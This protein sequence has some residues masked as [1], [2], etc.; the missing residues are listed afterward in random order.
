MEQSQTMSVYHDVMTLNRP[1]IRRSQAP[2]SSSD[3]DTYDE[4]LILVPRRW[5]ETWIDW[6]KRSGGQYPSIE[7]RNIGSSRLLCN[8]GPQ[9]RHQRDELTSNAP[10][11]SSTDLLNSTPLSPFLAEDADYKPI[12][13]RAYER[14]L[15]SG[16]S[17]DVG[18][19][20]RRRLVNKMS[21]EHSLEQY[22]HQVKLFGTWD[23][24][25]VSPITTPPPQH[26]H[27][28]NICG[29]F[30]PGVFSYFGPE[31][32]KEVAEKVLDAVE[33]PLKWHQLYDYDLEM[34]VGEDAVLGPRFRR[35][36]S[37]GLIVEEMTE[38][39][40]EASVREQADIG[41]LCGY[42]FPFSIQE[43]IIR[44]LVALDP[45]PIPATESFGE[46]FELLEVTPPSIATLNHWLE[47][48]SERDQNDLIPFVDVND[49][50]SVASSP[51]G[52]PLE[53]TPINAPGTDWINT[54]GSSIISP[55]GQ[56]NGSG[57]FSDEDGDDGEI[58]GT[59]AN[60]IPPKKR[61]GD[62]I[63][64]QLSRSKSRSSPSSMLS[65]SCTVSSVLVPSS[66]REVEEKKEADEN[67]SRGRRGLQ[68][69]GNTCFMNSSLQCLS[70]SEDLRRYFD[71]NEARRIEKLNRN[72]E[73]YDDENDDAKEYNFSLD[74]NMEN[75]LGTRGEFA[76]VFA[77]LLKSLWKPMPPTQNHKS[78]Y[79][80]PYSYNSYNYNNAATPHEFKNVLGRHASQFMGMEQHDSQVSGKICFCLL[81]FISSF[82]N[83][84]ICLLL[85]ARCLQEVANYIIDMLHE[86]TNRVVSKPVTEKIEQGEGESDEESSAKAW[87][88]KL[89]RDDSAVHDIFMGQLKSVVE[90]CNCDKVSTTFDPFMYLTVE[91]PPG[92]KKIK[93][94]YVDLDG[95]FLPFA[96][97]VEDTISYGKLKTLVAVRLGFEGV[98]REDLQCV[99]VFSS[100]VWAIFK[101]EQEVEVS[102]SERIFIYQLDGIVVDLPS[103]PS[104]LP[105][106]PQ[107]PQNN[108][109]ADYESH[110]STFKRK[111]TTG[112]AR[113]D[114]VFKPDAPFAALSR[115]LQDAAKIVSLLKHCPDVVA[116][117]RSASMD[118]DSDCDEEDVEFDATDCLD[119]PK[120]RANIA[121]TWIAIPPSDQL[122]LTFANVDTYDNYV[123]FKGLV[124]KMTAYLDNAMKSK[125]PSCSLGSLGERFKQDNDNENENDDYIVVELN[126][127]ED[128]YN[129]KEIANAF[130]NPLLLRVRKSLSVF[131]LRAVIA[132]RLCRFDNQA[133]AS[134]AMR[135]PLRTGA[136]KSYQNYNHSNSYHSNNSSC[137]SS[138]TYNNYSGS[139]G[140]SSVP[141]SKIATDQSEKLVTIGSIEPQQQSLSLEG[142]ESC[143][144]FDSVVNSS[145]EAEQQQVGDFLDQNFRLVM[146][147][148]E[149][150]GGGKLED[151][152]NLGAFKHEF[153]T[154]PKKHLDGIVSGGDSHYGGSSDGISLVDCMRKFSQKEQLTES[155]SWYCPRCKDHVQAWKT[156][157]IYRPPKNLIVHLKRFRY[158]NNHRRQKIDDMVD[159]DLEGFN[160]GE[161]VLEKNSAKNDD[162]YVYDCF[163]VSN[164]F[165]G[166]GG[167]HYTAYA[168][169]NNQWVNFDDSRTEVVS[170]QDVKTPAA[171]TLWFK[172]REQKREGEREGER[173]GDESASMKT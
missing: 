79:S 9:D 35:S 82:N 132:K 77:K 44:L 136:R 20:I 36:P 69:L 97:T 63:S 160:I 60:D 5:W 96:E 46:G 124:E 14:I 146:L 48:Y 49:A 171:Y 75:C 95:N 17:D 109:K 70:H 151:T 18:G 73:G 67:T 135:L 138:S 93:G 39:R 28:A 112:S 90:C 127:E 118:N 23:S 92:K 11:S 131:G 98:K 161:F 10:N 100:K 102:D 152:F 137:Y 84:R 113:N 144:K 37:C 156:V 134:I 65:S 78:A 101:D 123:E 86:D 99:D 51:P 74:I 145:N 8:K 91:L 155:E 172:M 32:F 42:N 111:Y 16:V 167:G 12:T 7:A 52:T 163:A 19:G 164:H 30:L 103:F 166:L 15:S 38:T 116:L 147:L 117:E 2:Q 59:G 26:P 139:S 104:S 53:M 25:K 169:N 128:S 50:V 170:E 105:S 87:N 94:V 34:L 107:P 31:G 153:E 72:E 149:S 158:S 3:E 165:G 61:R 88:L 148:P 13:A 62:P 47:A 24:P 140:Y 115:Y 154:V 66:L 45:S 54:N 106:P 133:S 130:A 68:N 143:S 122:K 40:G 64:P 80:Q 159:F 125:R 142:Q 119:G 89:S 56:S 41:S 157:S 121:D 162:E 141:Y 21:E 168:K 6:A 71:Y 85:T 129:L 120:K 150:R 1:R 126:F 81:F 33:E 173:E 29:V 108:P 57:G 43:K 27:S 83:T 55:P 110:V 76:R 114:S 22:G 4:V 58:D